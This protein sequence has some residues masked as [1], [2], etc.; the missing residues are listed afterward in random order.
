L[1]GPDSELKPYDK[2]KT[3]SKFGNVEWQVQPSTTE[4]ACVAL[5]FIESDDYVLDDVLFLGCLSRSNYPLH[6]TMSS[7][8]SEFQMTQSPPRST[9]VNALIQ[10]HFFIA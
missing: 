9:E 6:I 8:R 4:K 2:K 7:I 5:L 3:R 10:L 1:R